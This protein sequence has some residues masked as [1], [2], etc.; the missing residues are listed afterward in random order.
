MSNKNNEKCTDKKKKAKAKAAE[1]SEAA[2]NA[3][4]PDFNDIKSDVNGSY[5]GCPENQEKPVQD[6]DDL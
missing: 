1:K 5:T 6:A 4:K 3:Y 2:V